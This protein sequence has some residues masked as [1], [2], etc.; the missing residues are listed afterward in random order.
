MRF[1]RFGASLLVAGVTLLS[2]ATPAMAHTELKSS[3]PESGAS[4]A[5]PPTQVKL[6]FSGPVALADNPIQI[7]GPENASWT[8]GRAEVA[9][10]VVTAPVQAV[11]PAGEYTLRYKVASEDS[12]VASGSVKFNLSAPASSPSS[13]SAAAPVSSPAP[14]T[15]ATP[16]PQAEETTPEGLLPVWLWIVLAVAVVV[17][18][19]VVALR[20]TRRKN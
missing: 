2:A 18:G 19:L 20:L 9:G 13:S 3:D 5:T 12:H 7:T 8:V 6:T 16:A 11:G 1:K 15:S 4:L 17:A 14:A 10:T